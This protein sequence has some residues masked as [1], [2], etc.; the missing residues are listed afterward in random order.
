MFLHIFVKFEV[1][2]PGQVSRMCSCVSFGSLHILHFSCWYLFLKFALSLMSSILVLALNIIDVSILLFYVGFEFPDLPLGGHWFF[3][4][5]SILCF[6]FPLCFLVYGLLDSLISLN[7][8]FW[9]GGLCVVCVAVQCGIDCVFPSTFCVAVQCGIDC[10][11]PST[12]CVAV[13]CGIDCVFPSAFC[14]AVQCGIDCVFPSTFC[15]AV[16]CG[17][18]CVF[19]ST[20]CVAVQCGIGCVF[21]SAFCVAVQCG[22]GCVFPSAFCVAVQCGIGCVFPSAFCVAVQCGIGCV[23]PSAF[24]VAVQC[25]IGC[26]FPSTFCVAVHYFCCHHRSRITYIPCCH[27]LLV[28]FFE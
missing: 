22:I 27:A 1:C 6:C 15:V 14:V 18:G 24:C 26:V 19:P 8:F 7:Y 25:G 28:R 11:F 9:C 12:F 23:F 4:Q 16:Q 17:I 2:K 3:V 5:I 13:Q 21:P 20:F 10:V